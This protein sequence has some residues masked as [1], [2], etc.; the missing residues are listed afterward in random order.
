[1]KFLQAPSVFDETRSK[2]VEQLR[3]GWWF[4]QLAE[5]IY[6]FDKSAP[7][8]LRPDSIDDHTGRQWIVGGGDPMSKRGSSTSALECFGQGR[9]RG[10]GCVDNVRKPWD[11]GGVILDVRKVSG[12]GLGSDITCDKFELG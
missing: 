2:P 3:V 10:R 8:M 6:G 7:E 12:R 5:F 4:A 1:M 11:D 9:N